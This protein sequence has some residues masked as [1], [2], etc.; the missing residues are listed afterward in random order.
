MGGDNEKEGMVGSAQES[1]GEREVFWANC[2][3]LFGYYPA[4]YFGQ[5][6]SLSS[7]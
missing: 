3:S 4:S 6:F 5:M 7:Q 1:R 2:C